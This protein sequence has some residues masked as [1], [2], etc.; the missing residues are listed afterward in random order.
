MKKLPH[1]N[2]CLATAYNEEKRDR[3][4][5][6]KTIEGN[7]YDWRGSSRTWT[8][9]LGFPHV[10]RVNEGAPPL[11]LPTLDMKNIMDGE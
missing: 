6:L 10:L 7:S 4:D 5:K 9:F 2:Y 1:F 3:E 8:V 11:P